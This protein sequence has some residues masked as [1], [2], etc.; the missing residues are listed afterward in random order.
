MSDDSDES[1]RRRHNHSYDDEDNELLGEN[2]KLRRKLK[3]LNLR[4]DEELGKA[5]KL[6][7]KYSVNHPIV[8]SP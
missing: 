5:A 3:K 1:P 7:V 8:G 2:K 6:K 4:I